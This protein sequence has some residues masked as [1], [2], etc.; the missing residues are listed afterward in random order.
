VPLLRIVVARLEESGACA[1][2]PLREEAGN[3]VEQLGDLGLAEQFAFAVGSMTDEQVAA[4][5]M[6]DDGAQGEVPSFD[7]CDNTLLA[8]AGA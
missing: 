3:H 7:G 2:D 1:N 6:D 8:R 4:L 5:G